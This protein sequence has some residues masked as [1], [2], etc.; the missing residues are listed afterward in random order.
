MILVG[1]HKAFQNFSSFY[2][3]VV[4]FPRIIDKCEQF[5]ISLPLQKVKVLVFLFLTQFDNRKQPNQQLQIFVSIISSRKAKETPHERCLIITKKKKK[6]P[7]KNGKIICSGS[8]HLLKWQSSEQDQR[9]L[10]I[11]KLTGSFRDKGLL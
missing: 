6:K 7:S 9:I 3:K 4:S 5:S 1:S 8:G 2:I 10:T 11:N